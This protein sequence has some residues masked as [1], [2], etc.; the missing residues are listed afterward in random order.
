[1]DDDWLGHWSADL[2]RHLL[3][4][5]DDN[6]DDDDDDDDVADVDDVNDDNDDVTDKKFE[7]NLFDYFRNVQTK[8]NSKPSVDISMG[9]IQNW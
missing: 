5:N 6:H 1:M 9:I 4:G 3:S 7:S 8:W 2:G